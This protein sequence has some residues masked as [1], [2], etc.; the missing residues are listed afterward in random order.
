[1]EAQSLGS[2]LDENLRRSINNPIYFSPLTGDLNLGHGY[3]VDLLRLGKDA[4]GK[5]SYQ[6]NTLSNIHLREISNCVLYG[7]GIRPLT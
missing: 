2:E 1:M 3:R 5:R 6:L 7:L 4:S